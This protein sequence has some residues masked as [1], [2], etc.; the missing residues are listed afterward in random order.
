MSTPEQ[1]ELHLTT[2]PLDI[3]ALARALGFYPT[4]TGMQ[5][6]WFGGEEGQPLLDSP[7]VAHLEPRPDYYAMQDDGPVLQV[8]HGQ[9]GIDVWVDDE[10]HPTQTH[11]YPLPQTFDDAFHTLL[12]LEDGWHESDREALREAYRLECLKGMMRWVMKIPASI[13]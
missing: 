8:R 7:A 10:Q 3:D 11:W 4:M 5:A 1:L 9:L 6:S 13:H 2:D 12:Q